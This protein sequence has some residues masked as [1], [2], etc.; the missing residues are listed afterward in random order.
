[1]LMVYKMTR[2]LC[3]LENCGKRQKKSAVFN[4][5]LHSIHLHFRV[6]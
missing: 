4:D 1:M 5:A 2:E 6:S 3:V